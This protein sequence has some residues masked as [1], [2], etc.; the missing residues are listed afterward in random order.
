VSDLQRLNPEV[1]EADLAEG[2]VLKLQ[3]AANIPASY[4]VQTGDTLFSIAYRFNLSVETLCRLNQLEPTAVLTA[5]Q[6]L[7]LQELNTQ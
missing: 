5:G 4:Q 2:M 6:Q 7:T 1:T 3:D